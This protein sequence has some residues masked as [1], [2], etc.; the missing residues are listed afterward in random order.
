MEAVRKQPTNKRE[1]WLLFELQCIEGE[2][3]RALQQLQA[4]ATLE[5]E[6]AARAQ[7]YRELIQCEMMRADVFA[8]RRAPG[9]ID[10]APAWL[11]TLL[12]A[13]MQMAEGNL[14]AADD[15]RETALNDAPATRGESTQIGAFDWL[16]D[17][18]S[19]LG[20]V[21]EMAVAG[22]YRWVPFDDMRSLTLAG[23]A[24]PV[25]LVWRPVTVI[26]RDATVLR[27]YI[28]ARYPDSEHRSTELKLARETAWTDLGRTGVVAVGQKTWTTDRGDF[29]LFEIGECR[30]VHDEQA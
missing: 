30:F 20:P 6:G 15:L 1:R 11:D 22:G 10:Q 16:A 27:G 24:T 23:L 14:S 2:W 4:W 18:D 7:L 25:D 21:C 19:R 9:F 26:L 3:Q 29:G 8:G 13:N 28:P 12:S 17:S 5:F